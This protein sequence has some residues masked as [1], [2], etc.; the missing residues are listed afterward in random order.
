MTPAELLTILNDA[1]SAELTAILDAFLKLPVSAW[2]RVELPG[3]VAV[4][5]PEQF[6]SGSTAW[7]GLGMPA[8]EKGQPHD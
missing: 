5:I 2:D 6:P 4:T 7:A 8:K 3:I 1:D